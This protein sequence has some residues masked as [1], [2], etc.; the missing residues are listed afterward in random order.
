VNDPFS[1]NKLIA[2]VSR[3]TAVRTGRV[4]GITGPILKAEVPEARI[5]ELMTILRPGQDALAAEVVGFDRSGALLMP[6]GDLEG[7]AALA[8]VIPAARQLTVPCGAAVLGRVLDALG[9]PIDDG[10]PL[11]GSERTP[12]MAPPPQPL[13]RK[14]IEHPI[15]TGVR[16]ID[17]V[18]TLGRGQ[19]VGIFAGA[20]V[21]KSTL[22]GAIARRI[23]ADLIVLALI[24]ERG[25]EV[26]GYLEEVLGPDGRRRSVVVV[27]TS[28]QPAMLRLRAAHTATAIAEEARRRGANV[29]LMMDSV[30]RFAR[31]L[32]E[33]GLAAG[34]P[35]GRQGFP[36]SVYAALPRLFERAG[37]SQY[38]SITAFYT[39][40]V[41]GDDLQEP[42]ADESMSL[43]DGHIILSRKLADQGHFPAI[44]ICSSK[45]RLRNRVLGAGMRSP[46]DWAAAVMALYQ[47]NYDKISL[48]LYEHDPS[49]GLPDPRDV[50]RPLSAFLKQQHA[51]QHASLT[52]AVERLDA[53]KSQWA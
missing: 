22:L 21:G 47:Q 12:M 34:E 13:S 23:E 14:P 6:L 53:L 29:V 8:T 4:T 11:A 39:V 9:N 18:L 43:L 30:T 7:V 52:E 51:E 17:A 19:R 50:Y 40:L 33:V 26:G 25:R 20:G 35:P 27:S 31:A 41:A 1:I 44:D 24:G 37:N 3:E 45:S 38:G 28:E 16:A 48:G 5:G 32:R 10:P 46:G 2:D 49:T 42:I 15:S 36:A